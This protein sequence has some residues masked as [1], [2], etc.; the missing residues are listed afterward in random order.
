MSQRSLSK[1]EADIVLSW[2]W[3]KR[4]LVT[5]KDVMKRLRCSYG[6]ARKLI[7][8]LYRK[9]W[10]EPLAKGHYHVVGAERGPKGVPEMNP[11]LAARFFPKPNFFAYRFACIHHGLLTQIPRVIH[12]AVSRL[13]RPLEL[14]NVRFEFIP[15]SKKRFF[16]HREAIVMGEKIN[17]ADRERAVLDALDRP[18]L[19]GGIEAAAQALSQGG[20]K[21]DPPTLLAYLKKYDDGALSRRFGYLC[22][23]MKIDLPKGVTSALL[24][25]V[26]KDPAF[27][28]SPQRWGTAG[29]RD[30][31]WNLIL[32]VPPAELLG[33]VRI[34]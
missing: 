33:E 17:V 25:Q 31:R 11:Y 5:V 9:G 4:R 30:K 22:E 26:K 18:D 8:V 20:H 24:S 28:G 29:D 21:L 10:I 23:L 16:G 2:E 3:E 34:G 1:R 7:H 14:K 19:V 13:K 12:V 15:L 6:Y 27:L 32:N